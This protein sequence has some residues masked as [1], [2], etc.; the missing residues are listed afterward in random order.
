MVVNFTFELISGLV[1]GLEHMT[2]NEDD[3]L[4]WLIALHLG[5]VRICLGK[6]SNDV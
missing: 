4:D 2:G 6:L 5:F 3:G 1:F